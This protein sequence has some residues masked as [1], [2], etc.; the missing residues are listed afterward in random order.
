MKSV[1]IF[2]HT[3]TEGPGYFATFLDQR[4]IPWQL[5]R[6]DEGE[7]VPDSAAPF[8]GICLMGGT[9]SVNDPL[10]WIE[11][12]CR[13]IREAVAS[14]VPVIGHCLGGQ[15]MSKALGGRVTKNPVKEIGWGTARA[16]PGEEAE[17]WFASAIGGAGQATVFQWHGETFTLPPGATRLLSNPF[18][19]NQM[20]ALGPH[21][22]M[23]CH[24]E[25]TES[26]IETWNE[27]WQ[28]ETRGL[29]PLP[30]SVQT[31]DEI[32]RQTPARLPDLR[33]LAVQL[34]SVWIRG[35]SSG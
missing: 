5:I 13:L 26:M 8:S 10:P 32:R 25:M 14:G 31:P 6:I 1:A 4:S 20:F 3:K 9:V 23:Q 12:S 34:Y 15:L 29:D 27:A 24:V 17:R 35:L 28:N 21:L 19:A 22:G 16:D 33:R 30:D 7:R 18:C 11:R 2:R